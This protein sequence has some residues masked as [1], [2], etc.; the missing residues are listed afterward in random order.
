VT[1]MKILI[2]DDDRVSRA[3]VKGIIRRL[4]PAF[5]EAENG[6]DALSVIEREDPDVLITDLRMPVF[7]GFELIAAL[8]ASPDH[9]R[10]PIICLSSV[11]E[12]DEIERLAAIG[13]NDY[14]RK[15]PRAAELLKRLNKISREHSHWKT[16]RASWQ[17]K[18]HPGTVIIID[19]D[20]EYRAFVRSVLEPEFEV[21][22]AG[23]GADGLR[24]LRAHHTMPSV[25]LV[26]DGLQLLPAEMIPALVR[27]AV[28]EA[29]A[30]QPLVLLLTE[31]DVV[32]PEKASKFDGLVRRSQQPDEF[33][34]RLELARAAGAHR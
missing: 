26:A 13:I 8:R 15:P 28:T 34:A 2:A 6:L 24:E 21:I 12:R 4:E 14:V 29:G 30:V 1:S 22:E 19:R 9:G 20:A 5:F 7:D 32:P 11:N 17:G 33:L 25:V 23:T 27:R 31:A 16:H 18:G 3:L 10:L